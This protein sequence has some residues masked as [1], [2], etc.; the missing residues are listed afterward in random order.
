MILFRHQ[1]TLNALSRRV[2]MIEA[3]LRV[4]NLCNNLIIIEC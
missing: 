3:K 4:S 2:F 1:E